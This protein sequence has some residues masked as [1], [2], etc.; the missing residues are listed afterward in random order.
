FARNDDCEIALLRASQRLLFRAVGVRL[1][2][3]EA[4][5]RQIE[6]IALGIAAAIFRIGAC[7]RALL[8]LFGAGGD[9]L[10]RN[11][12]DVVDLEAEMVETAGRF[13]FEPLR[14]DGEA[15]IA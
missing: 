10:L 4:V 1:D 8:R 13:A 11:V 3:V 14:Q 5:L 12:G 9:E 2:A 7:R 15:D 6:P